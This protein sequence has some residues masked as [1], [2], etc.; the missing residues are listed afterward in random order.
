MG[1]QSNEA[2]CNMWSNIQLPTFQT[3]LQYPTRLQKNKEK[4]QTQRNQDLEYRGENVKLSFQISC[5]A[6]LSF[7]L[8]I[9]TQ[10]GKSC[11]M[12]NFELNIQM[13][14][15]KCII[16][17]FLSLVFMKVNVKKQHSSSSIDTIT[18]TTTSLANL[19]YLRIFGTKIHDEERVLFSLVFLLIA[20]FG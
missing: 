10:K 14:S 16:N 5:W 3:L 4:F 2:S 17:L 1:Q 13:T 6:L 12:K 20:K 8:W 18:C 9:D 15:S 7:Q 11:K 19:M